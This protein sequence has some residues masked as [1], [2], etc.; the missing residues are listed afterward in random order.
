MARVI[1]RVNGLEFLRPSLRAPYLPFSHNCKFTMMDAT[2]Y[3]IITT[4]IRRE[5]S[6]FEGW[7]AKNNPENYAESPQMMGVFDG[8]HGSSKAL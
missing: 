5:M 6:F 8:T 3:S 7:R 2:T 1:V 4:T